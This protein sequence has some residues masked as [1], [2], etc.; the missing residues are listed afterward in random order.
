MYKSLSK[1][2]TFLIGSLSL[3]AA[4]LLYILVSDVKFL[5]SAKW[6]FFAVITSL[7]SGIA[8]IFSESIPK[9]GFWFY[10]VKVLS[11]ILVV[12]FMWVIYSYSLQ[13]VP[14]SSTWNETLIDSIRSSKKIISS[15][16]V[17]SVRT[18]ILTIRILSTVGIAAQ[19]GNI[20]LNGVFPD[21]E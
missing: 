9:K 6:L 17:E 21:E 13:F 11:V 4:G 10:F 2:I 1:K 14:G 19:I 18:M 12:L 15:E 3:I 16:I 7:G 5:N 8:F 20:V